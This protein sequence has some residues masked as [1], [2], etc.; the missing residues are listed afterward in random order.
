[1]PNN[2]QKKMN[3]EKF[4]KLKDLIVKDKILLEVSKSYSG[5]AFGGKLGGCLYTLINLTALVYIIIFPVK[6]RFLYSFLIFIG[7]ILLFKI[8]SKIAFYYFYIRSGRNYDFFC[9][10]YNSGVIRLRI[11]NSNEVVSAPMPW[12]SVLETIN[13]RRNL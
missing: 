13:A 6:G 9:A 3:E 7:L 10:A 4:S 12:F 11:N 1:M 2:C 5:V 8:W